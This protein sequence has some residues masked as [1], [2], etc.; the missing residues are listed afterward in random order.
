VDHFVTMQGK[1]QARMK[2]NYDKLFKDTQFQ[3]PEVR[4]FLATHFPQ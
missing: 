4:K 2:Q 3:D 1:K